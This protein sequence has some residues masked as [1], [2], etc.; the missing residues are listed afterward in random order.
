MVRADIVVTLEEART[1]RRFTWRRMTT[2]RNQVLRAN[3]RPA[4]EFRCQCTKSFRCPCPKACE[5]A[6]LIMCTVIPDQTGCGLIIRDE[7]P[8][9]V[10]IAGEAMQSVGQQERKSGL[11]RFARNDVSTRAHDSDGAEA[12]P[13]VLET[14]VGGRAKVRY[15]VEKQGCLCRR[16]R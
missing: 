2:S 7:L 5:V 13:I 14:S 8:N 6:L 12:R 9:Y 16:Q 1:H 11:L 15:F 3:P 4:R 10:V